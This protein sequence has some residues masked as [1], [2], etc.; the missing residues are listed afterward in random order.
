MN[1][2]K[3]VRFGNVGRA[4]GRSIVLASTPA[5]FLPTGSA[6][7]EPP[8]AELIRQAYAEPPTVAAEFQRDNGRYSTVDSTLECMK[9]SAQKLAEWQNK[10]SGDQVDF[11]TNSQSHSAHSYQKPHVDVN[12]N[13]IDFRMPNTKPYVAPMTGSVHFKLILY[14]NILLSKQ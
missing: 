1:N 13:D 8:Q 9:K 14:L 2:E 7:F 12:N 5:S 6:S 10:N 4:R 3:P 11:A